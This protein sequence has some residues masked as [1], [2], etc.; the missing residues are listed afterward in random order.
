MER[1]RS[2]ALLQSAILVSDVPRRQ[3]EAIEACHFDLDLSLRYHAKLSAGPGLARSASQCRQLF[4]VKVGCDLCERLGDTGAA[5]ALWV[6][7][8]TSLAAWETGAN[9]LVI[10]TR[11]N[12]GATVLA[13]QPMTAAYRALFKKRPCEAICRA[14]P[15]T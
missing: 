5:S 15:A 3:L 7:G 2:L 9:A 12:D 8:L 4:N 6:L 11:R 10:N 13:L 1:P 14:L